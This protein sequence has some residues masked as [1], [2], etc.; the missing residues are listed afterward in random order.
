MALR[1]PESISASDFK[2]AKWDEITKDKN[3]SDADIPVIALLCQWYEVVEKCIEEL[4]ETGTLQV[5]FKNQLGDI[6]ECPQLS[7]MK[8]ASAEIRALNKQLG[9]QDEVTSQ[10]KEPIRNPLNVIKFNRQTRAENLRSNTG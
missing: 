2:S 7:T 5:A 10:P 4:N 9:I 6:K 1:K 8:K 3:F